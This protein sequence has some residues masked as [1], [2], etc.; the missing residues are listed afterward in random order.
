M[1]GLVEGGDVGWDL[2][3]LGQGG[4]MVH[5]LALGNDQEAFW[6]ISQY[7]EPRVWLLLDFNSK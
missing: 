1:R 2:Q 5:R 3:N 4:I 6:H 7:L